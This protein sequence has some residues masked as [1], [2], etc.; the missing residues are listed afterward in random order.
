MSIHI[1]S[2]GLYRRSTIAHSPTSLRSAYRLPATYYQEVVSGLTSLLS[3]RR[4][5]H[6]YPPY[7]VDIDEGYFIGYSFSQTVQEV[8][9]SSRTEKK[10]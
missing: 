1:Q 9:L 6:H 5:P 4:C 8:I 2:K 3:I 10:H 7:G